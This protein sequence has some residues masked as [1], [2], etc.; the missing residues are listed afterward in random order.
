[1]NLIEL[2]VYVMG[3]I[4]KKTIMMFCGERDVFLEEVRFV[5]EVEIFFIV[6]SFAE[7]L[8]KGVGFYLFEW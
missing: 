4:S 8:V 7:R 6:F 2:N 3:F 5:S 1:M